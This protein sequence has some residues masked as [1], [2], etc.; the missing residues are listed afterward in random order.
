MDDLADG[1]DVFVVK[2]AQVLDFAESRQRE[3]LIG[4]LIHDHV[5]LFKGIM[6]DFTRNGISILDFIHLAKRAFADFLDLL[7][8]T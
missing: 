6:S 5:Q 1:N 7:E 3:P 2:R 8:V 4:H